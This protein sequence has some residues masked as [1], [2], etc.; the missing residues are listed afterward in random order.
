MDAEF[1]IDM[2]ILQGSEICFNHFHLVSFEDF[3]NEREV[4]WSGFEFV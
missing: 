2:L 4:D 3:G 1:M